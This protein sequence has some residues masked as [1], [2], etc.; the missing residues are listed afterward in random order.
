MDSIGP[1]RVLR[2]RIDGMS[3]L[4]DT[5][6]MIGAGQQTHIVSV[7]AARMP[8][9]TVENLLTIQQIPDLTTQLL[10]F[11]IRAH[12]DLQRAA[13]ELNSV[14]QVLNIYMILMRTALDCQAPS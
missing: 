9:Y 3:M 7:V 10:E 6:F 4:I 11:I 12:T 8:S 2:A 5:V 1:F 13:G 14:K